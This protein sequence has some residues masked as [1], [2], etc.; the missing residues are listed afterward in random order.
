MSEEAA[1]RRSLAEIDADIAQAK[2][3]LED[4]RGTDC[5]VYA[6]IVG[7]YRSVRNWN[8]GKREEYKERKM[9]LQDD[10][11]TARHLPD[12]APWPE[13]GPCCG[14]ETAP[15]AHITAPLRTPEPEPAIP[16]HG[17]GQAELFGQL[18]Q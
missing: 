9:F 13:S 1:K 11:A 3:E 2:K 10:A 7:Y 14:N 6:R 17:E 16:E 5:E 15:G 12:G 4:A 18:V 8:K